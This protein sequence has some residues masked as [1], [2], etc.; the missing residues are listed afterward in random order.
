MI[1][2]H[3]ERLFATFTKEILFYLSTRKEKKLFQEKYSV[4]NASRVVD[5]DENTPV[6]C[7]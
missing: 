7:K 1:L 2:E 5:D 4:V 3:K 6:I